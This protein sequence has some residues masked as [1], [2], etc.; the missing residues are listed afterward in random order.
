[1]SSSSDSSVFWPSIGQRVRLHGLTA[2]P[3]LNGRFG[4]TMDFIRAQQRFL[5]AVDGDASWKLIRAANLARPPDGPRLAQELPVAG[6]LRFA[7]FN[8]LSQSLLEQNHDLLYR[9]SPPEALRRKPRLAALVDLVAGLQADVVGLQEVEPDEYRKT[10]VP[11]LGAMGY[12]GAFKQRTGENRE[13]PDGVAL[14][15]RAARLELQDEPEALEYARLA[16]RVQ[17]AREADELR[18]KHQVALLA[19][20]RDLATGRGVVVGVTH[21]LWNPKRGQVKARQV[22]ALMARAA[23]LRGDDEEGAAVVVLGDFNCEPSSVLHSF[24]CDGRLDAPL[25]DEGAWDG[26]QPG[27]ARGGVR[28]GMRGGGRRGGRGSRGNGRLSGGGSIVTRM[29]HALAGRLRSAYAGWGEPEVSTY[30]GAHQGTVDSILFEP[31]HMEPLALRPTPSRAEH[32][33]RGPMPRTGCPSDHVPIAADLGW[34]GSSVSTLATA[35]QGRRVKRR[36]GQA[37]ATGHEKSRRVT[38]GE[39]NG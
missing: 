18:N 39:G 37:S 36:G 15:W 20:L 38:C 31:A 28:G 16:E 5:V 4:R 17:D 8:C 35:A 27:R 22:E 10:W 21:I 9:H 14:F 12:T 2:W 6:S 11:R 29:T 25:A 13:T 30:H 26:Q 3:A 23:E 1:M 19:R 24:V 32:A 33:W 7:S 34:V